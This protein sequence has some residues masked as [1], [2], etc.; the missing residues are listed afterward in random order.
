[1]KF[2]SNEYSEY[3]ENEDRDRGSLTQPDEKQYTKDNSYLQVENHLNKEKSITLDALDKSMYSLAYLEV[4]MI[5]IFLLICYIFIRY[6]VGC[7]MGFT[8]ES[9]SNISSFYG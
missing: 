3:L 5:N 6:S 4:F 8:I 9:Q 7:T 2:N 1:M